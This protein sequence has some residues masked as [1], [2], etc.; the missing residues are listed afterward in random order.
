METIRYSKIFLEDLATGTGTEQVTLADGRVVSLSKVRLPTASS[1]T[2]SLTEGSRS[3]TI[4][5]GTPHG[6]ADYQISIELS[7]FSTWSPS[8][9]TSEGFTI[10]FPD[11]I[12]A[13]A[14]MRWSIL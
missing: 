14:T 4:T 12:P 11:D 10:D 7:W 5:L 8:A 2:V 9:K 6:S 3:H 13:S 1:G